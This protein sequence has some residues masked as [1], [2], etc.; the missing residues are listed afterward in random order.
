MTDQKSNSLSD[1]LHKRSVSSFSYDPEKQLGETQIQIDEI[2]EDFK[3]P[4]SK[5]L[6]IIVFVITLILTG[7]IVNFFIISKSL[8]ENQISSSLGKMFGLKTQDVYT[9]QGIEK[10]LD[11]NNIDGTIEEWDKLAGE[12]QQ[13]QKTDVLDDVDNLDMDDGTSDITAQKD[14][15]EILSI[16]N[17]VLL[18]NDENLTK[19][20]K[21]KQMLFSLK[22]TPELKTVDIKKHPHYQKINGYL[23]TVKNRMKETSVSDFSDSD[24]IPRLFIEG[25]PV[26]GY[27][28]IIDKFE[29][30]ELWQFLSKIGQ[31][32]IK[33]EL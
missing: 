30:N 15:A 29:Q 10:L 8:N 18:V 13:P 33:L 6:D 16:N 3:Q 9:S 27:D 17:I 23:K 24:D 12:M 22:M 32:S 19:Q 1:K 7:T 11:V 14:L 5:K 28:D 26:A 2:D 25:M 4:Q 31:K 20:E 21:A